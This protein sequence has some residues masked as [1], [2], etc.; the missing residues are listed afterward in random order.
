MLEMHNVLPRLDPLNTNWDGAGFE[1]G[2]RGQ[3]SRIPR[4]MAY[5]RRA[6]IRT[7]RSQTRGNLHAVPQ[8]SLV[9]ESNH[10]HSRRNPNPHAINS[11]TVLL[12]PFSS[13]ALVSCRARTPYQSLEVP[14]G[15]NWPLPAL[16]IGNSRES[17]PPEWRVA[18]EKSTT[19]P[20]PPPPLMRAGWAPGSR[21][22]II[23]YRGGVIPLSTTSGP[24]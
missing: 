7:W 19:F 8:K 4:G 2:W 13:R 18:S 16:R 22:R 6:T 15:V 3:H 14:T 20:R 12:D 5:S 17:D 11:G 10:A 21:R 9:V 24:S 23:G 1:A